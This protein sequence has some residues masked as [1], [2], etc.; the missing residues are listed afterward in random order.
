[1]KGLGLKKGLVSLLRTGLYPCTILTECWRPCSS[2]V[3]TAEPEKLSGV[4]YI[5][6]GCEGCQ[7]GSSSSCRRR[8]P[9]PICEFKR[10]QTNYLHSFIIIIVIEC[11]ITPTTAATQ[12]SSQWRTSGPG[13]A[14]CR[15]QCTPAG[16]AA[17]AWWRTIHRRRE[18][19]CSTWPSRCRW[20]YRAG[21]DRISSPDKPYGPAA[22]DATG[23]DP[24]DR[25]ASAKAT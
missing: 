14:R 1:M 8:R 10:A 13:P 5:Q 9:A 16:T 15:I 4:V 20:Q 2:F 21:W 19:G 18:S 7:S 6:E 24:H 17:A 11:R 12:T 22:H 23:Y 25:Q 3:T